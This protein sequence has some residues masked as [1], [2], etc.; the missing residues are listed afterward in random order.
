MFKRELLRKPITAGLFYPDAPE[1]LVSRVDGFLKGDEGDSPALILPHGTYKNIGESCGRAWRR[2]SLRKTETILLLGPVHR[3]PEP[4]IFFPESEAFTC[5]L[6]NTP[7]ARDILE[8]LALNN[9]LFKEDQIPHEEEHSLELTLPFIHRLFPGASIIPLLVGKLKRKELKS[10]AETLRAT[11]ADSKDSLLTVI[12]S[13]LSGYGLPSQGREEA[14]RFIGWVENPMDGRPDLS[15]CGADLVEM[16]VRSGLY[17]G[18]FQGLDRFSIEN[19]AEKPVKGVFYG[20]F[21]WC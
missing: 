5:P 2:S 17:R 19:G 7:V 21:F 8:T 10:A 15:A 18:R 14:D 9:R 20:T 4:G 3:D 16:F 1:E 12:S 6:G 13:N 11:L